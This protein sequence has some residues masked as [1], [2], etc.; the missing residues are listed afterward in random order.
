M[1]ASRTDTRICD[2]IVQYNAK[3]FQ[4]KFLLMKKHNIILVV[5]V[6]VKENK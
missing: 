2:M 1:F 3:R 4:K 6:K 5:L